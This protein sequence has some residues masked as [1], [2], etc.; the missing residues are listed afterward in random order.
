MPLQVD[1]R[2]RWVD[3]GVLD[4]PLILFGGPYS[5]VHALDALLAVTKGRGIA[6]EHMISTGDVV[7]YCADGA[8]CMSRLR[9]HGVQVVA[10]N[11][12]KQLAADADDCGCGF[13]AGSACDLLSAGWYAHARRRIDAHDRTYLAGLSDGIVFRHHGKRFAVIHGGVTDLSRFLWPVSYERS[14]KAEIAA[15]TD[16]IGPVDGVIAGHCGMAFRREID[17]VEWINA[18]TI[19]MPENDGLTDTRFLSLTGGTPRI[20]HLAYDHL[21][22][23]RAMLDAGLTQGYDRALLAGFWPSEDVLP[24][25]LRRN[26]AV[27]GV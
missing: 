10:G 12:E 21:A 24:A 11:C 2:F 14:F 16:M 18:G 15:I 5:N 17:G 13:G 26:P 6:P 19:G 7:A 4:V 27:S 3:L 9:V 23:S 8:A 22:A 1:V 25:S 20:E